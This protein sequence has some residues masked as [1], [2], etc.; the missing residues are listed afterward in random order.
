MKTSV[1]PLPELPP[2]PGIRHVAVGVFDGV[3]LGHAAV[4]ENLKKEAGTEEAAVLTFD[5]HPLQVIAPEK[6]PGLLT[7][8]EERCAL[9]RGLGASH[10]IVLR[11]DSHLRELGAET[12]VEKLK[13]TFPDL[14]S[15]AV[16]ANFHFGNNRE[17]NGAFL[18]AAGKRQ[19]FEVHI[20]EARCLDGTPIS[21][22]RIRQAVLDGDFARASALLGRDYSFCGVVIPGDR[23]GREIGFPTANLE[24]GRRLLPP[25]GVYAAFARLR[26]RSYP[27]VINIG[28]RPTMTKEGRTTVEVHLPNFSEDLY[29][30]TLSISRLRFLRKEIRFESVEKLKEQIALDIQHAL[31]E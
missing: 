29:G 27:A 17:G 14:R 25:S 31:S 26:D 6:A 30:E 15:V 24:T 23:R 11:F 5:P 3:H 20:V 21:S 9:L 1:V 16:G 2:Q 28:T 4:I 12:F 22:S 19:G 8:L 10:L 18:T 7:S 13:R